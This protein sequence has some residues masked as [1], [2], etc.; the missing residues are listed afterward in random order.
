[1]KVP[2]VWRSVGGAPKVASMEVLTPHPEV[3]GE[4][5]LIFLPLRATKMPK[6]GPYFF[7]DWLKRKG[8][9][10]GCFQA[11]SEFPQL[12]DF[13]SIEGVNNV[14]ISHDF[15]HFGLISGLLLP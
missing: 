1:M 14:R 12:S 8:I 3:S 5:L 10:K 11:Q 6:E 4:P 13:L 2:Q 9:K 7:G 15:G